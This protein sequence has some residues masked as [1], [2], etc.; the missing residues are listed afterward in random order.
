MRQTCDFT[1]NHSLAVVSVSLVIYTA[2][3]KGEDEMLIKQEKKEKITAIKKIVV[4]PLTVVEV[5]PL[6][7]VRVFLSYF[8]RLPVSSLDRKWCTFNSRSF[9]SRDELASFHCFCELSASCTVKICNA[10][11]KKKSPKMFA[12]G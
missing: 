1:V 9:L 7:G 12:A 2:T 10:T 4:E 11:K 5:D 6:Y 3:L 8:Q